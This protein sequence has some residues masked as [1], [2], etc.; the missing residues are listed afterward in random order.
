M[1]D[2]VSASVIP[3]HQPRPKKVKTGAERAK[4][5]RQRKKASA[6]KAAPSSEQLIPLDFP[7]ADADAALPIRATANDLATRCQAESTPPP[8]ITLGAVGAARR[9]VVLVLLSTA[10]LALAAVGIVMNGLF[11]RSLGSTDSAGWLFMAVGVA[12]D[13]TALVMPSCA[14][15]LW[16]TSQRATALVGWG[17]WLMTFAFAITAGIGFASVNITDVTLARA[18][19]IT[20]AVQTAQAAL[21][22]ATAARDRECKGGVG[23]FCREREAAVNDRRQ[24]LDIAMHAVEQTADPQTEAAIHIVAWV[25]RGLLR[26]TSDDFAMLRLILLVMLPQIGGILLMVGR[27]DR[28]KV[29]A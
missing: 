23:K 29:A 3:L 26:P 5:Y 18:A 27:A 24:A 25:S 19:R 16:H 8:T 20:P 22:D 17:V 12:A 9:P 2:D 10:A 21:A 28:S 11:A 7:P 1:A 15:G 6:A 14:A 4:T 13:L